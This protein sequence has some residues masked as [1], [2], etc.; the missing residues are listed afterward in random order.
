MSFRQRQQQISEADERKDEIG[1]R[2]KRLA[3]LLVDIEELKSKG[4]MVHA[5]QLAHK[6]GFH[7][8]TV[9]RAIHH[10]VNFNST[11][12]GGHPTH[13]SV[14]NELLVAEYAIEKALAGKE[15][16]PHEL[17][18]FARSIWLLQD[19]SRGAETP[20]FGK[21]WFQGFMRRNPEVVL[22][23]GRNV[24]SQRHDAERRS[25][26]NGG[27]QRLK[28]EIY[29]CLPLYKKSLLSKLVLF[30]DEKLFNDHSTHKG[31][32]LCVGLPGKEARIG[33]QHEGT[34]ASLGVLA[35]LDGSIVA[36]SLCTT[37][38]LK[39]SPQE[40]SFASS[41][42]KVMSDS[43]GYLR[44]S[45]DPLEADGTFMATV[46]HWAKCMESNPKYGP[47]EQRDH[48]V[49]IVDNCAV[50]HDAQAQIF[51]A[52]ERIHFVFLP[53]NM[54]H[55][56][57]ISDHEGL[58]GKLQLMFDRD[59]ADPKFAGI[60]YG[61]YDQADL[62]ENA[63]H[64]IFTSRAIW[65]AAESVGFNYLDAPHRRVEITD[66]SIARA[67]DKFEA[68]GKITSKDHRATLEE[69]MELR[70]KNVISATAFE[71]AGL[72]RAVD[73]P[74]M[75]IVKFITEHAD[76]RSGIDRAKFWSEKRSVIRAGGKEPG[77]E[78]CTAVAKSGGEVL[79]YWNA[80][81]ASKSEKAKKKK[82]GSLK[83]MER[84]VSKSHAAAKPL[85]TSS[86]PVLDDSILEH[87]F[88]ATEGGTAAN[89]ERDERLE[90]LR[91]A[92]VKENID[93][94]E[95][96]SLNRNFGKYLCGT[97]DLEWAL[98]HA[99]SKLREKRPK[100]KKTTLKGDEKECLD[101]DSEWEND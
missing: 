23:R 71:K 100:L 60:D 94:S 38:A 95:F 15:V 22:H 83:K 92:F 79:A 76:T 85:V 27:L 36:S 51:L 34:K 75:E 61:R 80:E 3:S 46:K 33:M 31:G 41:T 69:S 25:L 64:S 101:D 97:N 68:L 87:P 6:H 19:G 44:S 13:L 74:T 17:E 66:D 89:S 12:R 67:L 40:A 88:A 77:Y 47:V 70:E 21:N 52:S 45:T 11:Q 4:L 18:E 98:G 5:A 26:V 96:P 82:L 24:P 2:F 30:F 58:H 90:S 93:I 39:M 8:N 56:I 91:R 53:P 10:Q 59:R 29:R 32:P 43:T 54:T 7:T 57:Q 73:A 72:G 20:E 99:K 35:S 78:D 48:V 9:A 65:N 86:N 37:G 62:L 49:I 14:A 55:L 42:M 50:H 84:A 63:L 16:L 28:S 1:T 81:V